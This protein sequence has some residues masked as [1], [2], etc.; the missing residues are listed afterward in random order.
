MF[1]TEEIIK[2]DS[3]GWCTVYFADTQEIS[4][5]KMETLDTSHR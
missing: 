4:L 5:S 3:K 2:L 1:M